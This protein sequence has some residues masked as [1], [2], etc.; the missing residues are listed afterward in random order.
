M[1]GDPTDWFVLHNKEHVRFHKDVVIKS[2]PVEQLRIEAA[3]MQRA[4]AIAQD[5]GLFQ[6][7]QVRDFDETKG[8]VVMERIPDISRITD[9][10]AFIRGSEPLVSRVGQCL[11]VIHQNLRLPQEMKYEVTSY[12]AGPEPHV[13]FHGDFGLDNICLS[14][15]GTLV[16]LDWQTSQLHGGYGTYGSCYFDMTWFLTNLFYLRARGW[17]YVRCLPVTGLATRFVES[18]LTHMPEASGGEPMKQYL[19]Q[20]FNGMTAVRKRKKYYTWRRKCLLMF[21]LPGYKRFIRNCVML[22]PNAVHTP[23]N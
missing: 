4:H 20:F 6:V 16:I 1:T 2:G 22:G 5:C 12:L 9:R 13:F 11:A 7:P 18:Y 3:K 19:E 21:L 10:L 14:R 17:H 8:Q 15:Q 23:A